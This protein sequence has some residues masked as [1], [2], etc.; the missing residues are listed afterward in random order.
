MLQRGVA[1]QLKTQE[2]VYASFGAEMANLHI[3]ACSSPAG[4]CRQCYHGECTWPAEVLTENCCIGAVLQAQGKAFY[5]TVLIF[6]CLFQDLELMVCPLQFMCC[7]PPEKAWPQ[8]AEGLH[9]CR[10]VAKPS[11]GNMPHM[12]S[13]C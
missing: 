3:L 11:Y 13:R 10:V 6:T 1:V 5:L 8:G 7:I 12:V 4:S 9:C 2:G